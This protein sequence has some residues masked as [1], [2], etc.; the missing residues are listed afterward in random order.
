[1][2]EFYDHDHL[3]VAVQT[4]KKFV[5]PISWDYLWTDLPGS[6]ME[7]SSSEF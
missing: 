1:M 5:A 4:P 7:N 3:S 2:K 6:S